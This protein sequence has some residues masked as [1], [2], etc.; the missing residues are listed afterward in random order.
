MLY[1]L[2]LFITLVISALLLFP[3]LTHLFF[4]VLGE[5]RSSNNNASQL[6]IACV[7]TSYKNIDMALLAADSLCKQNYENFHIYLIADDCDISEVDVSHPLLSVMKPEKELGSKVRSMKYAS[8]N[9]IRNHDAVAI[10]DPDNLADINFLQECNSYLTA[11]YKAVQGR[12]TA[13]NLD[14]QIACLDAMGEVYYNYITKKVPFELGSSSVIA[15]SGMVIESGLFEAFF[16][17]SYIKE[18]FDKVIPGEDKI[19]HYF[20]VLNKARIAYNENAIL[21]DEKISN[22]GMV[23]N[24]RARWINS[25][26]LNLKNAGKL[27]VKGVFSFNLNQF[28]SGILTLYPPLFLLVLSSGL[29]SIA[30][31]FFVPTFSFIIIFS[32]TIF[33]MNFLLVLALN[34]VDSRIWASIWGIPFFILNQMLALLNIKKSNKDFLTTQNDKKISLDD[35]MRN[36]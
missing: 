21:Y 23:K 15:G 22:A 17:M 12:R 6:D 3:F 30:A 26:L 2:F 7:I 9:F 4:L 32:F 27:F 13:K 25:Y 19:L 16:N 20:I 28:I 24:Q 11:G 14:T 8:E 29:I 33:V 36:K 35:F 18:N 1:S 31:L 10:F 34:K 5:S